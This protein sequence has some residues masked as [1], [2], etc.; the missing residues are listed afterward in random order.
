[1]KHE[2]ITQLAQKLVVA[3]NPHEKTANLDE[4]KVQDEQNTNRPQLNKSS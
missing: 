4:A 1:M 2:P 3:E